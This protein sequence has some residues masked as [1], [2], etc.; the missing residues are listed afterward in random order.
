MSRKVVK[1]LASQHD[2]FPVA[3][4]GHLQGAAGQGQLRFPSEHA[5]RPIS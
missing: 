2:V 3:E 5:V 1:R 4:V